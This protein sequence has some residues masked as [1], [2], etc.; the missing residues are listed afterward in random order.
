MQM[1]KVSQF[2]FYIAF[3]GI[4]YY[5]VEW[6]YRGYSHWSMFI[7]GGICFLFMY[8]QGS[9]TEWEDPIW[10]QIIRCTVFIAASEFITGIIVNKWLE[11]EIWDY[12]DQPFQI[13]GQICLPF[14]IMFSALSFVGILLCG[15][16]SHWIY[17]EQKPKFHI[18]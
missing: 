14:T 5:L 9:I 3:G 7:L 6:I 8:L 18:I 4:L 17:G 11:W 10:L 2:L 13:F 15:N 16:I 12:S 1:K